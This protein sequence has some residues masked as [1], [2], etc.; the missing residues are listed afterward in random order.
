MN[1]CVVNYSH[2]P[3]A[4]EL[5]RFKDQDRQA[6]QA[7]QFGASVVYKIRFEDLRVTPFYLGNR[8][9]L[10]E[11]RGA[12]YW[13][14][15]PY[16]IL[17]TMMETKLQHDAY[18]YLDSDLQVVKSLVPFAE[19]TKEQDVIGIRTTYQHAR[20]CKRDVSKAFQAEDVDYLKW[21]QLQAGTVAYANTPGAQ[22]FLIDW[23]SACLN[24]HNISDESSTVPNWPF[25]L[26]HRHDQ[27]LFT[28]VYH[29]H[30]YKIYPPKT[31]EFCNLYPLPT[32]C[33]TEVEGEF[34]Q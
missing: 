20:F 11:H 16:V 1:F 14:W 28:L 13:A 12:G 27:S 18:I 32:W 2:Y 21:Y 9:L 31:Q 6:E 7:L 33:Q 10:D 26:E 8:D 17:K 23:L 22:M 19:L 3:P 24:K 5:E 34:S 29:H 4:A 15:K 25:F 30:G